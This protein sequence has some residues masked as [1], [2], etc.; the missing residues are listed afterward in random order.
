MRMGKPIMNQ[1]TSAQKEILGQLALAN[2]ASRA[3]WVDP[4]DIPILPELQDYCRQNS[5]GH[6]A[7]SWAGPPA[8][9]N[10][11]ELSAIVHSCIAGLVVQT[12]GQLEDAYDYPG[13]LAAKAR[14]SEIFPAVLAAVRQA[15]PEWPT[16]GLSAGC[17]SLCGECTYPDQPCLRPDEAIA[18]VE[19]YG[20]YVNAMLTLAGLR[21]NNGPDTVSYVGLIL[22]KPQE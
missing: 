15:V 22:F 10:V 9:G 1:L 2:G 16:I 20:I 18:P 19:G 4:V 7:T 5:C 21:Y 11:D 13:M 17:C 8:I 12:I 3:A 6:Y 14:H